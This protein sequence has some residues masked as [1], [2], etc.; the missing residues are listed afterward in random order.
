[1]RNLGTVVRTILFAA[2]I[3]AIIA[4][5]ARVA[6]Q[7]NATQQNVPRYNIAQEHTVQG[8]VLEVKD[9]H[10]PVSGTIGTHFS[11]RTDRGDFE[12]HM[13]PAKFFKDYEILIRKGMDVSVTGN[14]VEFNGKPAVIARLVRMGRETF[15]FRDD[16]GHPNW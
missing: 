5:T 15:A 9:Y 2:I 8:V 12:V 14:T 16:K 7:D 1:M 10:C 6:A 13:A 11:L 3:A 4:V